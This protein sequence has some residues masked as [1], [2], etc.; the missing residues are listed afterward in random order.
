MKITRQT[1]IRKCRQFYQDQSGVI[2]M[3]T[4]L[5]LPVILG[6]V[7]LGVETAVWYSQ[8]NS[9]QSAADAAAI[10]GAH[11]LRRGNDTAAIVLSAL[12]EAQR[13]G[14]S[15]SPDSNTVSSPPT[16]GAYTNDNAVEV[17][18][19]ED[20]NLLF[21]TYFIEGI[22]SIEVRA[23]ARVAEGGEACVL[24]LDPTAS[25]AMSFSGNASVSMTDCQ[26][27]SNSTA[28]D[29]ITV[30]GS[31]EVS[32]ECVASAG[33]VEATDGLTLTD[34]PAAVENSLPTDDPYAGL[35][36]PTEPAACTQTNYSI[37]GSPTNTY[38]VSPGRY[39]GGMNLRSGIFTLAPGNY[40]IDGGDFEIRAGAEVSGDGV[41]IILVN[42]ETGTD[43]TITLNGGAAIDLIAPTDGD[44]SGI[45]FFQ[46]PASD[47]GNNIFN[48]NSA[49]NLTGVIY[50][51]SG[52]ISFSG[53]NEVGGGCTY[54]V[55]QS[56]SFTGTATL[57][58]VCDNAGTVPI[59]VPGTVQLVE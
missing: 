49:T 37:G 25:G 10:A 23:V 5:S 48:G 35:E 33:G 39:C 4:A 34:C 28:E 36:V 13:N 17:K 47:G 2:I 46:D 26:I 41:T 9:L 8:R 19:H 38:A 3:I 52:P 22:G 30:A 50:I 54:L 58:N 56:I 44:L 27:S 43:P 7:A 6:F 40:I 16:S 42:S 20:I 29:S 11:E 55:A 45:L 31:G 53:N 24:A 21:S 15:L 12:E 59:E 14:Y 57:G 18:L 32:T 51:P 1:I